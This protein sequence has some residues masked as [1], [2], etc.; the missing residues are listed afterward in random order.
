MRLHP[1]V[2][3]LAAVAAL[4]AAAT[5]P[6]AAEER[7]DADINARIRREAASDSRIMRTVH[8]L[9]DVYGPRV[10]GS[11]SLEAAGA[12][13][14][15]ELESWGLVNGRLEP[16]NFGRPGWTNDFAWGAI[17][18]PVKDKLEFEVLGW[19]P[20]T[21][22]VVTARAVLIDPPERPTEAQLS[23]YLESVRSQVKGAMVLVG[24]PAVLPV[25]F[26]P[27][28]K[29]QTGEELRSQYDPAPARPAGSG[30]GRGRRSLPRPG[31]LTDSQV[32]ARVD[33]FLVE[34]GAAVRLNDAARAHGQIAAFA[35]RTYDILRSVPTVVVRNEDYGRIARLLRGGLPVEL[36]FHIVNRIHPDGRTAYNAVAE[37]PGTDLADEVVIIGAHLDSWHAATGATDNAV[38]CAVMMEAARIL[39]AVGAQP[40][41]TIRVALWSGEEQGLLGSRAYVAGHFGTFEDPGPAYDKLAAYLNLDAGTGRVRGALVFG[42]PA[43]AQSMRELLRPFEDL[44]V[45]G[46]AGTASRAI[47][48]TDHS[49]FNEAGLNGINFQL[50]PIEYRT[51]THHTSLDTYERV[52]EED[53]RGSAIVIASV[54][55]HLAMR[56]EPL[57]RFSAAD[58]PPRPD[59]Q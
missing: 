58:M 3:T 41:R 32:S 11:P 43:A 7:I 20:A 22:G 19:T 23:A 13:A 29:R 45:V 31:T 17:V 24:A 18:A 53:A 8:M 25:D 59:R 34:H 4:S 33:A 49:S 47:S 38:G 2:R 14:V 5:L 36:Q 39:K 55:Y 46:V 21:E 50:D 57:P 28:A 9:A 40:R 16:W 51:H 52:V 30:G 37:I 12:W 27:P 48:G 10:T 54:A 6:F 56:D 44:G 1:N 42:P 35:N 26:S 15:R